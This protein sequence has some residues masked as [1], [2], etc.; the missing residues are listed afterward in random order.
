[1]L[2]PPP[3]RR[4]ECQHDIELALDRVKNT[5]A[6]ARSFRVAG[7]TKGK[8]GWGVTGL[9]YGALRDAYYSLDPAIRSW[10]SLAETAYVAGK[11]TTIDREIARAD[12]FLNRP[13]PPPRRDASWNK[14]AVAA[15]ND[16]L[17]WWGYKAAVTRG[18][19]ARRSAGAIVSLLKGPSALQLGAHDGERQVLLKASI[20]TDL[21]HRH[22]LDE[23]EVSSGTQQQHQSYQA[24][25]ALS[26]PISAK[27]SS[28]R[29][30]RSLRSFARTYHAAGSHSPRHRR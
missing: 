20:G 12:V 9:R 15:A 19:V 3:G 16:L 6:A 26:L 22:H 10:F 21:T 13:S 27:R 30:S 1:L 11:P 28:A 14:A 29:T 8:A 7:S 24:L 4:A 17:E 5:A 2:A 25:L 23:R 18:A